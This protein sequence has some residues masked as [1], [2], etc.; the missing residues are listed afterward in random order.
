MKGKRADRVL[1]EVVL[2]A[3]S[4]HVGITIR[5][6]HFRS[7]YNAVILAVHR[8][9][10]NLAQK[11]RDIQLEVGDT[12]LLETTK[13]FLKYHQNDS[14]FALVSEI[15]R[16]E[17]TAP[18]PITFSTVFVLFLGFAMVV[19]SALQ[20]MDLLPVAL[21]VACIYILFGRITWRQA[22]SCIQVLSTL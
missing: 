20:L 12:L 18:R 14:N 19:V 10:V 21:A 9:G 5:E 22:L 16:G 8:Q 2:A 6:T 3:H 11:I 7:L 17:T 15:S 4:P 1:V 13:D